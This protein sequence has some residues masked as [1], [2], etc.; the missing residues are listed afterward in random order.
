MIIH[1]FMPL[2]K[3][4][5]YDRKKIVMTLNLSNQTHEKAPQRV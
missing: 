2:G 4:L 1:I 3:V 5:K